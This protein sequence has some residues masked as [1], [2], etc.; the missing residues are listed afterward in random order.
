M[1][2]LD[3]LLG[4]VTRVQRRVRMQ[5]AVEGLTAAAAC[6]L[7]VGC[8]VRLAER[9]F[10][11]RTQHEPAWWLGLCVFGAVIAF[12]WPV[13]REAMATRI[14]R[15]HALHDRVRTALDFATRKER[16][17][18]MEA[19]IRDAVARANALSPERAAPFSWPRARWAALS[20]ALGFVLASMAPVHASKTVSV[21][22]KPRV[23]A[24]A[25]DELAAFHEELARL[26][27]RE[28]LSP[29]AAK[30]AEAYRA[31]LD[32]IARGELDR[33]EAIEALL[34]LEKKLMLDRGKNT[35]TD[36]AALEELARDLAKA[37]QTLARTLDEQKPSEAAD[38]LSALSR[39]L[40]EA[41]K[42]E[43]ARL[44]EALNRIKRRSDAEAERQKRQAE[45]EGLLKRREQKPPS[46]PE[47]KR[48][49]ERDK[50]E[51]ER[52]RRDNA[53][54]Q[55]RSRELERLERDLAKAAEALE[56]NQAEEAQSAMQK[57]AEDLR[58]FGE[59]Q[60][61]E[62]QREA[63]SKQLSQLRELLQR[64]REQQQS[65]GKQNEGKGSQQ[66]RRERFSLR[67]GGQ[68][69]DREQARI[70]GQKP[71]EPGKEGSSKQSEGKDGK[72][73]PT[74]EL[75]GN[76]DGE[77]SVEVELPGMG[78]LQRTQPAPSDE[79]DERTLKQATDMQ[80]ELRDSQVKG[81]GDKGPT[82]SEVILDAADRGFAT[83]S[84]R[85]VFS[86]Y[87]SHAEEVLD[88]EDIPGGYRFYVRRYFQLIRPREERSSP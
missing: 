23:V 78:M 11:G 7:A 70:V 48:L 14:D 41:P 87:R 67:A 74:L 20:L 18:F 22:T 65:S 77:S 80:G 86:D 58:R 19:A 36:R 15:A 25:N 28:P 2:E 40:S 29:D 21:E 63:L 49:L 88:R 12:F 46:T 3:P 31:L 71:G 62:A 32:R 84:Y 53:E 27:G 33:A 44:K 24:L 26:V 5:R 76:D 50:R 37:D 82:R 55:K 6:L 59:E 68:D 42:L 73:T 39:K 83:A 54:S 10:Y 13:S 9:M 16:S 56:Q 34:S 47:E 81:T 66:E 30:A 85:K 17:D 38:A 69:P 35:G 1:A 57:G 64:Q 51:L 61:S 72:G 52:L 8:L 45:L 60:S 4:V 75:G 79:H 43:S